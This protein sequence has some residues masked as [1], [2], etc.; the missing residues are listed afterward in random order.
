LWEAV[1]DRPRGECQEEFLQLAK[2]AGIPGSGAVEILVQATGLP[3]A[4][5]AS[6]AVFTL[7]RLRPVPPE[8]PGALVAAAGSPFPSVRRAAAEAL[9]GCPDKTGASRLAE[10]LTDPEEVVRQQ[11]KDSLMTLGPA[12][13]DALIAALSRAKEPA[14]MAILDVLRFVKDPRAAEG[15]VSI[16][17][18]EKASWAAL[19]FS[20]MA[21]EATGAAE[22]PIVARLVKLLDSIGSPAASSRAFFAASVLQEFN[23]RRADQSLAN[24]LSAYRKRVDPPREPVPV[25]VYYVGQGGPLGECDICKRDKDCSGGRVCQSYKA[26]FGGEVSRRCAFEWQTMLRCAQ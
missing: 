12:A 4:Q 20:S 9:G 8:V 24:A 13:A 16:I 1:K 3:N 14:L 2:I 17:E 21:L 10:L 11:A 22:P 26:M 23:A 5:A 15:L 25:P 18:D 7:G 6:F 19:N